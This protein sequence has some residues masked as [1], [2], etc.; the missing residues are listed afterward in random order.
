MLEENGVT[1]GCLVGAERVEGERTNS[2]VGVRVGV[3]VGIT[4]VDT[5]VGWGAWLGGR[6]VTRMLHIILPTTTT[7]RIQM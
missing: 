6:K 4:M 2:L 1:S 5:G 7:L 3:Q